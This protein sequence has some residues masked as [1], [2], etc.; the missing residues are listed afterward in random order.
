MTMAGQ[1]M[2]IDDKEALAILIAPLAAEDVCRISGGTWG[3]PFRLAR[4]TRRVRPTTPT[5]DASKPV[6]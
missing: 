2:A 6:R 4:R 3:E 5:D 1:V